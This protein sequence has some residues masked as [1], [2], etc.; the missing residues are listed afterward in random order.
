MAFADLDGHRVYL[1]V[2]PG[3]HVITE[4]IL[5]ISQLGCVDNEGN[6]VAH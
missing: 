5:Y 1:I 6:I 3:A 2:L 4:Y